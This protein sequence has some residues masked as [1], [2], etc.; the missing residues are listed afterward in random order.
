MKQIKAGVLHAA[1]DIRV[2]EVDFPQMKDGEVLIKIRTVGVCGSD[3]HYYKRGAIG[4][5]VVT[6]PMILGHEC[7]GEIVDVAKDVKGFEP[8]DRVAVEPGHTCRKCIYCKTGRYNLCPDVTFMATPPIDGAC[9]EY[10]TWPADFVF[11]LPDNLTFDHG[12]LMEPLAVGMHAVRRSRLRTGESVAILGAGTIGLSTL[13]SAVAAGAGEV[14]V[15]DLEDTRLD[16]ARKLGATH[17]INASKENT[18]ESIKDLTHGL[19][20]EV[21]IETAGAASTTQQTVEV[22]GRGGRVVWV[23]AAGGQAVPIPI[24]Q[25]ADKEL[26]IMGI[27]RYANLYPYAIQ[28]VSTGRINLEGFVTH[29]YSLTNIKE[30]LEVA[31][32]RRDGAIK[33]MINIEESSTT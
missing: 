6:G 26:D 13:V 1:N 19:G 20:T 23:G 3:V 28:L 31:Y 32:E 11:H 16:M 17:T 18:A 29:R 27:F 25:V 4:P 8:G 14:I 22:V 24:V 9:V 33:V 2:E 21:V 5:H 15:A 30:A 12:A 7:A 10:V